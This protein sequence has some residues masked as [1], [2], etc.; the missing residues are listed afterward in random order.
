MFQLQ[1]SP[2]E[3]LVLKD[4]L[5]GRISELELEILHTDRADFKNMLKHHR[6]LLVAIYTRIPESGPMTDWT[7]SALE[8]PSA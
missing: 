3:K 4:E 5:R 8:Q 2:D 6:E 7:Q 1:L